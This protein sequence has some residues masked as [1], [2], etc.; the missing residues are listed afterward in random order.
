MRIAHV[1]ATFPPYYAGTGMVCY[2]SAR[3]LARLGHEVTVLTAAYGPGADDAP[4]GV[5]VRRLPAPFRIGNA[6]L[7]PGLL[8]TERFDVIHLHYP[9]IFG[10]EMIRARALMTGT[11]YV[12]T[13]HN[14]LIGDGARGLLFDLYARVTAPVI[15]GGARKLAAVSLDHAVNCR[16]RGIF[17]RRWKD[18]VEVP[19]GVD[20]DIF[21]PE[22]DGA[23]VRARVGISPEDR[24]VLFVGAMDRAHHFK[25]VEQLLRALAQVE[26]Q[27]VVGL[28]VGEGD[29][30]PRFQAEAARLGLA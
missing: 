7:L 9:F 23:G 3:E 18:V 21:T 17:R 8:S 28:L 12:L 15:L 16:L 26:D 5:T 20:T 19:N 14:D 24:V 22:A 25:G 30:R 29:L 11:P 6:P 13:H 1:T 4:E 27:R 10:A 2:R